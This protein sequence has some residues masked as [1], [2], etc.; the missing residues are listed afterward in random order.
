MPST[1]AIHF[2]SKTQSSSFIS[3]PGT[4]PTPKC[5]HS[6]SLNNLSLCSALSVSPM[7]S[8]HLQLTS[9]GSPWSDPS[10]WERNA[11][12]YYFPVSTTKLEKGDF[13]ERVIKIHMH[14]KI[15]RSSSSGSSFAGQATLICVP[16]PWTPTE[17]LDLDSLVPC[18][19]YWGAVPSIC[20]AFCASG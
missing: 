13:K 9:C 5:A 4:A 7:C 10:S 17:L 15:T 18:S 3:K 6:S 19:A 1:Q 12:G 16:F 8:P 11:D 20:E 14:F 2:A